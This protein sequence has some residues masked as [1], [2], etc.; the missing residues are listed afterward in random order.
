M[1]ISKH[2]P[3]ITE[4]LLFNGYLEEAKTIFCL[5]DELSKDLE[6]CHNMVNLTE[7]QIIALAASKG[8]YNTVKNL[9]EFYRYYNSS[10]DYIR[11]TPCYSEHGPPC[12]SEHGPMFWSLY[13]QHIHVYKLLRK[14]M[15][16][17][18]DYVTF[19]EDTLP[20]LLSSLVGHTG[21][22]E[23][24]ALLD[25]VTLEMCTP[26]DIKAVVE[27]LNNIFRIWVHDCSCRYTGWNTGDYWGDEC[28]RVAIKL[29]INP[30]EYMDIPEIYDLPHHRGSCMCFNVIGSSQERCEELFSDIKKVHFNGYLRIMKTCG[31]DDSYIQQ[32]DMETKY[33]LV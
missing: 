4:L 26:E 6:L 27:Q 31:L 32:E 12:Y 9:I 29:K 28:Y 24:M 8:D 13:N 15:D 1:H 10:D 14:N 20:E 22:E 18:K 2:L 5:S 3:L 11:W 33:P 30:H 7:G 19:G 25:D 21:Y 23:T 17:F 16:I